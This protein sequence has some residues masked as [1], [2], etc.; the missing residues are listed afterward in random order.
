MEKIFIS[1]STCKENF[2]EQ[3]VKSAIANAQY[4]ERI[5]IGVFNSVFEDSDIINIENKNVEVINFRTE[6]LLGVGKSRKMATAMCPEDIDYFLQIDAHIIFENSWDTFLIDSVNELEKINN[7]IIISQNL[8]SWLP[9]ENKKVK[10]MKQ[11]IVVDPEDV[12]VGDLEEPW[13]LMYRDI[14]SNIRQD[15]PETHAYLGSWD[16]GNYAEIANVAGNFIFSRKKLFEEIQQDERCMWGA[17]EGIF[18]MRAWT[19]GYKIF[20][21]KRKIAHHLDKGLYKET[22]GWRSQKV[23]R[24]NWNKGYTIIKNILLGKELG[25]YGAPDPVSLERYE[26]FVNY[27]FKEFYNKA[28]HV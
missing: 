21:T 22:N 9:E 1:I 26:K 12:P 23:N 13:I 24:E 6:E 8:P 27:S 10:L 11:G 20:R 28:V 3:T 18:A 14:N 15:Y 4:P 16:Y 19:R 2:V 5:F 7:K 25:Y 17:D